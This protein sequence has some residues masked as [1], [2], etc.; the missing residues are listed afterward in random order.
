MPPKKVKKKPMKKKVAQKQT[1]HVQQH[2]NIRIGDLKKKRNPTT[3]T[4]TTK[5]TVREEDI[6]MPTYYVMPQQ[7]KEDESVA[8]A[9]IK[10]LSN[11]KKVI[12]K[13]LVEL[14]ETLKTPDKKKDSPV[15]RNSLMERFA[16]D[17]END[18][19]E[20]SSI[21]SPSPIREVTHATPVTKDVNPARQQQIRKKLGVKNLDEIRAKFPEY[22]NRDMNFQQVYNDLN[23]RI[24]NGDLTD[25]RS[26]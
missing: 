7:P 4:R 26:P 24:K 18:L 8:K 15:F 6:Q 16:K 21:S 17:Y 12:N 9:L 19:N 25:F 23:R 14:N 1:T 22:G 3:R 2:V 5:K 13:D 10:L 20:S 11:E